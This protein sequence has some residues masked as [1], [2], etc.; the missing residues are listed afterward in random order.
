VQYIIALQ[1]V[2]IMVLPSLSFLYALE[3]AVMMYLSGEFVSYSLVARSQHLIL[4]ILFRACLVVVYYLCCRKFNMRSNVEKPMLIHFMIV[5][6]ISIRFSYRLIKYTKT[7]F[8]DGGPDPTA[9]LLESNQPVPMFFESNE[10]LVIVIT[11]ANSGIGKETASQLSK[12]ACRRHNNTVSTTIVLGCRTI[13]KGIEVQRDLM[14]RINKQQQNTGGSISKVTIEVLQIELCSFE[15]IRN[16]VTELTTKHPTIHCLI[17]NAGV[18]MKDRILTVDQHET[19]IQANHLGHFL[20]SCLLLPHIVPN[21]EYNQQ[22]NIQYVPRILNV[23][24]STYSFTKKLPIQD[25]DCQQ[26]QYSLFDQYSISKMCNILFTH[27]LAQQYPGIFTAAIH[28]GIVRTQVVR[29]MPWFLKY[30]NII[31]G[32]IV[33]TFQKTPTQ[34]SWCTLYVASMLMDCS[35]ANSGK[36]WSNRKKEAVIYTSIE[37]DSVELWI[38]SCQLVG[39]TKEELSR[40][41]KIATNGLQ[42][43]Q[44]SNDDAIKDKK[45]H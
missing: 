38:K 40:I 28:P 10:N 15:S 19:T 1:Y 17:N 5:F 29:N 16:A 31:F 43:R 24:S 39:L 18:M 21:D 13:D 22:N 6:M 34:G 7:I 4:P 32:A 27:S 35:P 23:T 25:L 30:P 33:R 36:Y 12:L 2:A 26:R 42:K 9:T 45:N 3:C 44:N 8:V 14:N 11:G 37:E 20:L 41:E